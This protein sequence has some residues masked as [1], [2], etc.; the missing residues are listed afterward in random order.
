MEDPVGGLCRVRRHHVKARCTSVIR[1][2]PGVRMGSLGVPSSGPQIDGYH[3][4]KVPENN[5]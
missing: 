1:H 5:Y 4:Y 2:R 3:I